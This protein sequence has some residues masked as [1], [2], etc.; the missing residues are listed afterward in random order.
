[1]KDISNQYASEWCDNL[2]NDIKVFDRS[3]A[4]V[5]LLFDA[6]IENLKN[7]NFDYGID[8]FIEFGQ[9]MSDESG[10]LVLKELQK[11]SDQENLEV[12]PTV[13]LIIGKK[14]ENFEDNLIKIQDAVL[15]WVED[16]LFIKTNLQGYKVFVKN[17]S[18]INTIT[19][20]L[21]FNNENNILKWSI[22]YNRQT[23][24]LFTDFLNNNNIRNR[25]FRNHTLFEL[26][27]SL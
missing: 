17:D 20:L 9:L 1:M 21:V 3:V 25:L 27:N 16:T 24:D 12:S 6:E 13:F 15:D 10:Q 8:A 5:Q 22:L 4:S 23:L 11:I 7:K 14:V 2:I 26:F 18:V 19:D